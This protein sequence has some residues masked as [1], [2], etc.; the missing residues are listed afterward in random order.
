[1][2]LFFN[3]A[4]PMLRY[5]EGMFRIDDLNPQLKVS[6]RMSR[7]EIFCIGL[8]CITASVRRS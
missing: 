4:G 8:R 3:A 6:W 7:W 1:M 5:A 2:T